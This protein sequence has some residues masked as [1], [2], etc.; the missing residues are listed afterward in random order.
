VVFYELLM[1]K[2]LFQGEDVS[3]TMA[4]VIMQEPNLD[5]V[6]AQVRKLLRRCLEKDP[7]KR[8]RD[9]SGVE[10]LL[11]GGTESP[12][13]AESLPYR[14]SRLPWI[15]AGVLAVALAA[16]AFLHLREA[17]PAAAPARFD[18]ALTEQRD[19]FTV[20]PDGR[21]LAYTNRE[22]GTARLW[23]RAL[24]SLEPRMLAGTDG[25]TYPFWSPDGANL[26]FFAQGKLKKIA[27]AGGPAQTLCDVPTPRGASWNRDGVIIFSNVNGPLYRVRDD[28]GAPQP[29]TKLTVTAVGETHRYPEF[30]LGGNRF[31]YTYLNGEDQGGIY[32]GSTD[33]SAPVRI[34]PDQSRGLYVPPASGSRTGYVLF[35][36]E[37]AL[38]ALP[39]DPE[40]LRATGP[41]ISLAEELTQ[42]NNTGFGAFS[43]SEN[44]TLFYRRSSGVQQLADLTWIDR[45]GKRTMVGQMPQAAASLGLSPDGKRA[46]YSLLT[47]NT[48]GDLWLQDL[49]RET[50]E[51]FTFDSGRA[52][53][54]VWAP[55]GSFIVYL[56]RSGSVSS[57]DFYRKPSNSAGKPELLLKGGINSTPYDISPDGKWLVYSQTEAQTKNDLYLL[58]LQGE[59]KPEKYLDSPFNEI[60]G[61]FSPDG[62][63]MAYASDESGQYQVYVQSIPAT[64]EKHQV[65][66]AGGSYPRWTRDGKELLYVTTDLKVM[67]VPV[68]PG[69]TTFEFSAA[70]AVTPQSLAEGPVNLAGRL[71][72]YALSPDGRRILAIL[73]VNGAAAA[74]PPFTVW[75]NWQAGLKK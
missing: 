31:L 68:K 30:I 29:L 26:G 57:W 37:N 21:N 50:P 14:Q 51:R 24:D 47:S 64:G 58:P 55:D 46:A 22:A 32:A 59:H 16:V 25:V 72:Q 48:S 1:G 7:K 13:Q 49:D 61:Q 34:L 9:I 36:R 4:A 12:A 43:A 38:M 73:P 44:G 27:L 28:G 8:L 75:M 65:S 74:A 52:E 45:S 17:P 15:A 23:V 63:W 56:N 20:S 2:R 3:H 53:A 10:L 54:P 42:T 5:E 71:Y 67:S 66:T 60:L 69:R 70:Q 11:E 33:G 39:F 40:K 62:K 6:P 35:L 41:V 18:L 19:Y